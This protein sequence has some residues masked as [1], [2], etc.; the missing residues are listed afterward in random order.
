V[1]G[2]VSAVLLGAVFGIGFGE[3]LGVGFGIV[4]G[5]VFAVVFGVVFGV[6]FG[7]GFGKV[8]GVVFPVASVVVFGMGLTMNLWRPVVLYPFLALWNIVLYQLDKQRIGTKQQTGTKL[9]LLRWNSAFWD[10]WQRIPLIGLDK[11][12]LLVMQRNLNEGQA[13]I[14]YLRK[15]RQRWAVEAAQIKL[16]ALNLQDCTDVEAIRNAHRK[17]KTVE[18]ESPRSPLRHIFIRISEDVDA[19]LN[20]KSAYN[21]RLAFRA[22]VYGLDVQLQNLTRTSN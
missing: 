7:M 20:Q 9:S 4:F 2:V 16:D 10:E 1:Y 19:A 8:L 11:H 5:V 17:L 14:N 12:L 18:L 3:V 6:M 15:S 21:Q 13:A 22:V